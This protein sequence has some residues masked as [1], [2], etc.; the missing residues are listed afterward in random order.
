MKS[1]FKIT[2]LLLMMMMGCCFTA[3]AQVNIEDMD[4]EDWIN[5]RD[6]TMLSR[7]NRTHGKETTRNSMQY[8]LN[9]RMVPEHEDFSKGLFDHIY[10]GAFFGVENMVK[11]VNTREMSPMPVVALSVGKEI[12]PLHSVRLSLIGGGGNMKKR[13]E[14]Y[15]RMGGR[16]DYF[17]N[18]TSHFCGYSSIRPFEVSL[19][20]G[21]GAGLSYFKA[22]KYKPY[23]E[24]HVGLQ[25]KVYTGPFA[26]LTIEPYF[27]YSNDNIDQQGNW[28]GYDMFYGVGLSYMFYAEDNLSKA[29]RLRLLQNRLKDDRLIDRMSLEKWRTPWFVQFSMGGVKGSVLPNSKADG[30]GNVSSFSIGRWMSPVIGLRGSVGSRVT[31]WYQTETAYTATNQVL[32]E[33]NNSYFLYGKAEALFNPLGF[34]KT[35]SWDNPVGFYLFGG[36]EMGQLRKYSK[37][38]VPARINAIGYGGG[39]NVWYKLSKDLR[40][41]VEP[42][43]T[44]DVY[45]MAIDGVKGNREDKTM[46]VDLG[47]TLLMRTKRYRD[48][49]EFDAVQNFNY[50]DIRGFSVGIAGGGS[51]LQRRDTDYGH[52]SFNYNVLAYGEYRFNHLH[53]VRLSADFMN[54]S[55]NIPVGQ[56]YVLM[57]SSTLLVAA[58]DYQ[59]N[60]T[61]LLSG[62]LADRNFALEAYL[63]P[64]IGTI[65]RGAKNPERQNRFVGVNLGFKL[66]VPVSNGLTAVLQPNFYS[67][68]NAVLPTANPVGLGNKFQ[69]YQDVTV[70]V[71]ANTAYYADLLKQRINKQKKIINTNWKARQKTAIAEYQQKQRERLAKRHAEK[72]Y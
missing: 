14:D 25:F 18:L 35:F 38:S 31:S 8:I 61:N 16:A 24:A 13:S 44:V 27:G 64:A 12:T 54:L 7:K 71:Q 5:Q 57:T 66:S 47:L 36:A 15:Y 34:M 3:H 52:E 33:K 10:F 30:K 23:S 56:R 63:G 69:L 40:V 70:G 17:Y 42:H 21:I 49:E 68:Q 39:L 72:R 6:T 51:I 20:A 55:G 32:T 22:T 58:L 9:D 67:L 50:R 19:N 29:S 62:R 28:R 1:K 43:Y 45:R 2:S 60:L 11:E 4:E 53:A 26:S 37:F 46:G 59:I 41:F 65:V 48:P